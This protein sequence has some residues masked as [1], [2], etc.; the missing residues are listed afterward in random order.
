MR[1]I[2]DFAHDVRHAL[3]A[4]RRTPAFS[5]VAIA[6]IA[7]GVG[8]NTAVFSVI[9]TVM[10]RPLPYKDSDRL[11][12]VWEVHTTRGER[13]NISPANLADYR[14]QTTS[15]IDLAGY[16]LVGKNLT[17]AGAPERLWVQQ[18]TVNLLSTLGVNPAMGRA[19]RADEEQPGRD[20]VVILSHDFWV[21]RFDSAPD[22]V[23]RTVRLNGE[24]YEVVGVMP[25]GF[26]MPT[27]FSYDQPIS[28]LIPAAQQIVFDS[29]TT[30]I[31]KRGDRSMHALARLKPEVTPDQARADLRA[32][33]EH[34]AR[35]YP[36]ANRDIT[37]DLRLLRDDVTGSARTGLLVLL[38]AVGVVWLVACVNVA[39]L[40]IVR[41]VSRQ[42]EIAIRLGLGASLGRVMA[43]FLVFGLVLSLLGCLAGVVL[44]LSFTRL[45]VSVAPATI[46]RLEDVSLDWRVLTVTAILSLIAGAQFGLLPFWQIARV[47]PAD[48]LKATDRGTTGVAVLRWRS[49]LVAAEIASCV[50]L[51][52]GGGLLLNSFVRLSAVDLGFEPERV[53]AMNI[54]LADAKY[55]TPERRLTFFEQLTARVRALP[56]VSS[57][58]YANRLPLRGGWGGN[59]VIAYP[60]SGEIKAEVDLQSVSPRYF[61]VLGVSVI[62]GRP[63]DAT[64]KP[65]STPV[66]VVSRSFVQK[67]EISGDPIGVRLQRGQ[68][69][70]ITVVGVV[71][72]IRRGGKN[73][74]VNPQVYFP[75][76]QIQLHP[77]TLSDFAVR[78]VGDPRQLVRAVQSEVWAID[79]DQPVT[80]VKTLDE[81]VAQG[82]APRRFQTLLLLV[83]AGV[84]LVL[85]LIGTY[86]VLSYA[87]EQRTNEIGLRVAL[88]A[89]PADIQ[90]FVLRQAIKPIGLGL[91]VGL[92][93]AYSLSRYVRGLLFGVEPTDVSTFAAVTLLLCAAA[94]VA[95]Y[96]PARR[97]TRIMPAIA[98]RSE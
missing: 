61:D 23:G 46:P 48:L 17:E 44:G 54:N 62:R 67:F 33:S 58:A 81:I 11:V 93:G 9:S 24:P 30:E 22:A 35:T 10:L 50:I 8:I 31:G 41:A 7:L 94:F 32:V 85:A 79:K 73:A 20:K 15:F 68:T 4:L 56:G 88:G 70:W 65:E 98:L 89:E 25:R 6:T 3:R 71:N 69:P 78:T 91:A 75:A 51:L 64:D 76:A 52:V 29:I 38:G 96:I 19:F 28:L 72:D 53:L 74:A 14:A 21:Q 37:T 13:T 90:K 87:V 2:E 82:I 5:F 42:R 45:V 60:R 63:L 86:G 12:A 57:A 92:V 43:G 49:L 34:L 84:S 36:D 26:K 1:H 16:A 39:N 40:L 27:Q 18:A 80:N 59:V 95:C 47:Q 83:F 55:D 66:A 77:V 97:A